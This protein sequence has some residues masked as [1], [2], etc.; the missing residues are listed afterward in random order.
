M[1]MMKRFGWILLAIGLAGFEVQTVFSPPG[2]MNFDNNPIFFL[3]SS[4]PLPYRVGGC[5]ML[6]RNVR[7]EKNMF[8][9][10]FVPLLISNSFL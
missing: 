7:H 2:P 3:R 4:R 10:I 5:W 1:K 8:P 6:F 9:A